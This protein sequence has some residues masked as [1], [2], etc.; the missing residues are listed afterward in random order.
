[1][2]QK[3]VRL[4]RGVAQE[5]MQLLGWVRAVLALG[6]GQGSHGWVCVG[7]RPGLNQQHWGWHAGFASGLGH[8]WGGGGRAK[9]WFLAR[10]PCML[11]DSVR[12]CVYGAEECLRGDLWF[13]LCCSSSVETVSGGDGM[14]NWA[15]SVPQLARLEI[16]ME[17][18]WEHTLVSLTFAA[19]NM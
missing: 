2:G 5:D 17:I 8:F 15:V 4:R 18:G 11:S 13:V 16:H 3:G 10:Q 6:E 1:M 7:L 14:L 19:C 12:V 9:K